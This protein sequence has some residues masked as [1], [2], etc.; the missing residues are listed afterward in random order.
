[1]RASFLLLPL[2]ALLA[3]SANSHAE[4]V[5][6]LYS[7]I[8]S[9]APAQVVQFNVDV[10]DSL[11]SLPSAQHQLFY[12]DSAA[13]SWSIMP[14]S[15]LYEACDTITISTQIDYSPPS[16]ILDWYLRS[17]VD[18]VVVSQSPGNL[19]DQFPPPAYAWADMGAD[20]VGDDA[21]SDGPWL[22]ILHYYMTYSESR[23]YVKLVNGG[24]GFPTSSG[25]ITYYGYGVGFID[26]ER[27]D[28]SISFALAYANVPILA[29]PGLFR[30][31]LR[32]STYQRLAD[33]T[34]NISGDSLFMSCDMADL[35]DQPE[36][37]S[38]PPPC[39][40]VYT[41]AA[42]GTR[43][44]LSK[45][46]NDISSTGV[47]I[48]TTQFLHAGGNTAPTSE[49][50]DITLI[51]PDTIIASV[52]YADADG[53]LPTKRVLHL[54]ETEYEMTTC[55]K[56]YTDGSDFGC[57]FVTSLSG[58]QPYFFE[59]SDGLFSVTTPVDSIYLASGSYVPGDADG[60]AIV[61][62]SDA[63]YLIAYIFGGGGPPEP[64]LA[65]DS[66]C[67]GIVN[68]SDAV[69]LIAYIFGGGNAP[70]AL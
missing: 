30:L 38:W 52:R 55:D 32:D 10:G 11:L 12:R 66:D 2:L 9:S 39:G 17:E 13:T 50:G 58:W 43:I 18:T 1:M 27:I 3:F 65:G 57:R 62:I 14:I 36:W 51:E 25:L 46:S 5:P 29:P 60:N 7:N 67:N 53:H 49:S 23:L 63:V 56:D 61:N 42:T 69:Y 33:I 59:F 21:D 40:F 22:D 48:P 4:D 6:S 8:R 70:C 45:I 19:F 44:L 47:F 35:L 31:D 28:D 54:A 16:G 37:T 68:I 64:L 24:G 15:L 20:S 41:E 26:P 34:V